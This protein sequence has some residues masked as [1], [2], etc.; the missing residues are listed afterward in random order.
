LW[1]RSLSIVRRGPCIQIQTLAEAES[2]NGFSWVGNIAIVSSRSRAYG[3]GTGTHKS[4]DQ[5]AFAAAGKAAD[6]RSAARSSTHHGS[7]ALAF[8]LGLLADRIAA[9]W[10]GSAIDIHR[11][12]TN[13]KTRRTLELA[14]GVRRYYD[15][16]DGGPGRYDRVS[17]EANRVHEPTVK[18]FAGATCFRTQVT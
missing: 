11:D 10:V 17:I 15:T 1:R 5:G 13:R 7:G 18:V 3:S 16:T 8:A 6:Q 14:C 12:Q 9:D 4:T 2:E